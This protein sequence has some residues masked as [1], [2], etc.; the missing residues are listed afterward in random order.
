MFK[1]TKNKKYQD[2]SLNLLHYLKRKQD[3][4]NKNAGIRGGI[5]GSSPING[6]YEPKKI[7]SWAT[8]FYLDAYTINRKIL[9]NK[10]IIPLKLEEQIEW[11]SKLLNNKKIEYF[12]DCG[13][14]LGIMRGGKILDH[15]DDIDFTL[16]N[17]D[18]NKLKTLFL[19]IKKKNYKITEESYYGLPHTYHLQPLK[20]G[21]LEIDLKVFRKHQ[22]YGW[23]VERYAK[24]YGEIGL[25]YYLSKFSRA[26]F[27][28]L[29]KFIRIK[30]LNSFINK[31]FFKFDTWVIP[32][33][34]IDKTKN[35]EGT[36]LRI[37]ANWKN[38]L[39]FKYGN[40]KVP[41]KNWNYIKDD[42]TLK[43]KDPLSMGIPIKD[44]Y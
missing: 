34:Y 33:K 4:E 1:I 28:L 44:Y 17:K 43:H 5:P 36:K 12:V 38:Y 3:V 15:D 14:L 23:S 29:N 9:K 30:F 16:W 25:I 6:K 42:Q 40:W 11:I 19:E 27:L 7:L 13:T 39:K 21:K 41:N 37:P 32:L 8:K 18:I 10:K 22:N 31:V 24:N 35:L 20:G 2:A 26:P